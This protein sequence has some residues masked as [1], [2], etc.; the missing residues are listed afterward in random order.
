[1]F[2][3]DSLREIVDVNSSTEFSEFSGDFFAL[4]FITWF[5]GIDFLDGDDSIMIVIH[6]SDE[7]SG[8]VLI[9]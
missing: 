2:W 3:G 1:L 7:R 5:E 8:E 9:P 6:E 4:I